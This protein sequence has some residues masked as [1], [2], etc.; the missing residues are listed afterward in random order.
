MRK[1]QIILPVCKP[2][3]CTIVCSV[4]TL[5][6]SSR[7]CSIMSRENFSF[8]AKQ[9]RGQWVFTQPILSNWSFT[10]RRNQKFYSV[11]SLITTALASVQRSASR[12]AEEGDFFVFLAP[13]EKNILISC[14]SWLFLCN[15]FNI[16]S[17]LFWHSCFRVVWNNGAAVSTLLKFF[18]SHFFKWPSSL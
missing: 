5:Y 6:V 12:R 14:S 18:L 15:Y 8:F 1:S 10:H 9:N 13:P 16:V 11:S 7:L 3:S 4:S 2:Y 17:W